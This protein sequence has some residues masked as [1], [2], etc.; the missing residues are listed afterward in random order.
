MRRACI[1]SLLVTVWLWRKMTR[2]KQQWWC[3]T[4]T[5]PHCSRRQRG[6]PPGSAGSVRPSSHLCHAA[7]EWS[8]TPQCGSVAGNGAPRHSGIPSSPP[9]HTGITFVSEMCGNGCGKAEGRLASQ[10]GPRD[11]RRPGTLEPY[12][13]GQQTSFALQS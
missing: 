11:A 3:G 10:M 12:P 1:V 5:L 2:K 6:Q 7:R 4:A 9:C 8:P 13:A